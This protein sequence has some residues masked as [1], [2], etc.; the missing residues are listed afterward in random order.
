[1]RVIAVEDASGARGYADAIF[2]PA[3]ETELASILA[4]ASAKRI[5]VTAAGAQTGV[6]AGCVPEGGWLVSLSRMRRLSVEPSRATAGAGLSLKD[7]QAAALPTGQF[8]APDPTEYT[9]S[10]GGSIATNASGSRSFRYGDTRRHVEALRVA[11]M[12]GSVEWIE[13]GRPVPFAVPDLPLPRTTKFSAGMPLKQGMEF[14]DLFIGSEGVLGVVTEARLRLLPL[15]GEL[16]SGVVFFTSDDFAMNAVDAW[17]LLPGLRMLE[18]MDAGS[19]D[20]LRPRFDAIPAAAQAC[21]L[22]EDELGGEGDLDSWVE[23]LE[24]SGA[25]AEASWFGTEAA[26]RERFRVF[27]HALP[28]AVNEVVRQRGLT[29]AGTDFAV[30]LDQNRAMLSYY[31]QALVG[32]P[33][34]IF[35]HIGDAHVHVNLLPANPQDAQRARELIVQMAQHAVSLGGTVAAEHGLG[36]RKAHLLSLQW[37][38][39]QL[40]GMRAVKRRLDPHWLLGRGVLFPA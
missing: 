22:I 28:E 8:Y 9:A 29:K 31:R 15:P 18:Y 30:P 13:R 23:R 7:L 27:R 3:D 20:M 1:M 21:L 2:H 38:A 10:V 4:E 11:F 5:P 17:R 36:R 40:E 6:A 35:G 32:W 33:Y 19:L 39:E 26:D 16:L 37:N 24:H 25:L 12:D 14:V 34:V